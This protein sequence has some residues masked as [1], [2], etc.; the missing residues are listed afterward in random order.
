M[1][2]VLSTD[3]AIVLGA[4]VVMSA[5]RALSAVVASI[6]L[7]VDGFGALDLGLLF[8][9]IA[10]GSAGMSTLVGIFSARYGRRVFLVVVPFMAAFAALVFALTANPLLLAVAA[11]I[12]TFGRGAGAGAGSVGPYQP[13][14][15]ALVTGLVSPTD[16][17]RVFGWLAA[18]ASAG[19]VLGAGLAA[20]F[21]PS[22][23]PAHLA[24]PD[25]RLVF[26]LC[27]GLAGLAGL[28]A[29]FLSPDQPIKGSHEAKVRWPR[30]SGSLLVRLWVT[31]GVNGVAVG[32]FGP[33]VAYWFFRRFGAAPS[34]IGLI[35]GVI[36]IAT[37]TSTLSASAI[38]ARMGIVR[39]ISAVRFLQGLLLLPLAL[40]P[41][42]PVAVVIYLGRMMIQR[43][44]MPL[45]QSYVLGMAD[46]SERSQVAALSNVPSMVGMAA[47]PL[48]T[49]YLFEEVSLALPFEI[50]GVLQILNA[51][52]FYGFF[53]AMRPEE[54][55]GEM[56]QERGRWR[57]AVP[58][59][60]LSPY[61]EEDPG[62]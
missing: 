57:R 55:R 43:V 34:E 3:L 47:S 56:G 5:A 26:L 27:A 41:T 49:G 40:A 22:A 59:P 39:T 36:N 32:L 21:A 20:F 52:M 7:A 62:E 42:L 50:G 60:D 4:R 33:F 18:A 15:S 51:A 54:E 14:E 6:Y 23:A 45:R 9:L 17:N 10:M 16:R 46:P 44:G 12:G 19:A 1:G 48:L 13:A 28:I 11:V 31:N 35:F 25:F 29:L 30:K 24:L 37:I 2:Q 61:G 38:A 58:E 53:R 8:L